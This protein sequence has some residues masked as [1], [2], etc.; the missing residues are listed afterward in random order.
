[1]GS[2]TPEKTKTITVDGRDHFVY[3]W[4]VPEKGE[5]AK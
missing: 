3:F 4:R 2:W 5:E 1:M